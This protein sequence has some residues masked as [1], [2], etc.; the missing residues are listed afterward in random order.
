MPRVS[1]WQ[2]LVGPAP[3]RRKGVPGRHFITDKHPHELLPPPTSDHQRHPIFRLFQQLV[4]HIDSPIMLSF[5]LIQ[6][7]QFVTHSPPLPSTKANLQTQGQ[8][9][10]REMVRPLQRRRKD[11]AQRRSPPPRRPAR[12]KIPIQLRRISQLQSRLPPLRWPLL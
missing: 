8:N 11:Q 6:N 10:S 2:S 5:I 7:R 1:R 9:P 4:S 3:P 12:P